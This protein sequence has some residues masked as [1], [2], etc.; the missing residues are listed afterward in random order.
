MRTRD[1]SSQATEEAAIRKASAYAFVSQDIDEMAYAIRNQHGIVFG[2]IGTN[3]GWSSGPV[4]QIPGQ[5]ESLWYHFVVGVGYRM[6]GGKKYIKILNS[7]GSEWGE[8]G[9]A[10]ISEDYISGGWTFN[11]M[12]LLDL[13]NLPD[14][15]FMKRRI[16]LE[17]TVDQYTVDNGKKKLIPDAETL[18]DLAEAGIIAAGDPDI[19]SKTEFDGFVTLQPWASVLVNNLARQFYSGVKGSMELNQ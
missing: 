19:V 1:D 6:I 9:I 16:M 4:P 3:N 13:P 11:A 10:Y 14:K 15:I 7:W 12:T 17:Y 2:V 5:G 18:A 8:S